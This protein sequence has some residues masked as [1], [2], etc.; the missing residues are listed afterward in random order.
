M[1]DI[2][3]NEMIVKVNAPA[4]YDNFVEA[5]VNVTDFPGHTLLTR[6]I[7]LLDRRKKMSYKV[8]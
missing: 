7:I 2:S 3:I 6:V 5:L 1:T 4:F 8:H